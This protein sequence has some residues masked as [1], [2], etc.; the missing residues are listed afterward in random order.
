[1]NK[2]VFGAL[3]FSAGTLCFANES[4]EWP[5][6]D[7]EIESLASSLSQGGGGVG[8]SGFVK[9]SYASS[10]DVTVGGNDLGG[11]S[12]DNIRVNFDGAVG[13]FNVHVAAEGASDFGFGTF[14]N[15]GTAAGVGI[16]DA[17][18]SFNI[19]DQISATMG[20]FRPPFLGD[21]LRDEDELLFIDRSTSGDIWAFR[22][23][24][25]MFSGNFDQLGWWVAAQNGNDS[26]G[27]DLAL[28]ARVAFNAL[29][30]GVGSVEGAAGAGDE[31]NLTLAAGYYD[32]ANITDGTATCFEADYTRGA[33]SAAA[34]IVDYDNGF[35]G[36]FGGETPWDL[37]A[38]YM[39]S[40]DEWEAALRWDDFDD[41]NDTTMVT[42]GVNKYVE[43]H[44]AKWQLNYS[45]IQ[46]DAGG[47]EADVIQIGLTASV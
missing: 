25:L 45:A 17:W 3:A 19:T 4:E 39:I 13:A 29:G 24:G 20:T 28:S 42:A 35:S 21:A 26:A 7:R 41:S 10:S 1:M 23:Q 34:N 40:P 47:N 16:I 38:S 44:N 12:M 36:A 9:S 6:L 31:S 8:V 22:D 27:D 46:S 5:T 11:F 15:F 2:F 30:T 33:L 43:G 18:T 37:Q 32:D 14:G